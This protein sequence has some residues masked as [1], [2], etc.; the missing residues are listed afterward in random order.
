MISPRWLFALMA[1][2]AFTTLVGASPVSLFE[3][4]ATS[5]GSSLKL[6]WSDCSNGQAHAVVTSVTPDELPLGVTTLISGEGDLDA[7]QSGGTFTMDIKG[8]GGVPLTTGCT[9]DSTQD[10]TCNIGLGPISVG[11][12]KFKGVPP[13]KAGHVTGVPQFELMLPK[14]LPDFATASETTLRITAPDGSPTL[15]VKVN[16]APM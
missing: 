16:T 12:I 6:T 5:I 10:K 11:T 9:G 8:V 4:P 7:D 13:Q 1:T 15:C 14:G 2:S 3:W